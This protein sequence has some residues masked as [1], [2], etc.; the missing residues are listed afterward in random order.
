MLLLHFLQNYVNY[1]RGHQ[2]DY[3]RN[4]NGRFS[5]N[6]KFVIGGYLG[7]TTLQYLALSQNDAPTREGIRRIC[8]QYNELYQR[9]MITTKEG[10][11]FNPP[12]QEEDRGFFGKSALTSLANID[13]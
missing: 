5:T 12:D 7:L 11:Y 8:S 10:F 3:L 6:M 1:R 4:A 13:N 9:F 2:F